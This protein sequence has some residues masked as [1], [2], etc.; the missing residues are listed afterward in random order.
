MFDFKLYSSNVIDGVVR[1]L[2]R[3]HLR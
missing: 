2:H 1:R 3:L